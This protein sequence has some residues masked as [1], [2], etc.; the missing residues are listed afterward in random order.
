M[1]QICQNNLHLDNFSSSQVSAITHPDSTQSFGG[2]Q[3]LA[4]REMQDAHCH[5]PSCSAAMLK[6]RALPGRSR[7]RPLAQCLPGPTGL[8]SALPSASSDARWRCA[9]LHRE[10]AP[11]R[12]RWTG[13]GCEALPEFE[14]WFL[15][16]ITSSCNVN[17]SCFQR[18]R[19]KGFAKQTVP[20]V[21]QFI[22]CSDQR[23]C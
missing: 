11:L 10:D 3:V 2:W 12:G 20:V 16:V 5:C 14:G 21:S 22:D 6:A 23:W 4:D 1:F 8:S 13:A 19:Q 18:L 15:R 17:L 9:L 7:I